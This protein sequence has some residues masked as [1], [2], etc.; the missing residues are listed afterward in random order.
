MAKPSEQLLSF[1]DNAANKEDVAKLFEHLK[2]FLEETK[3]ALEE[4]RNTDR[5][6]GRQAFERLSQSQLE[7]QN[8]L[9]GRAN[10][11]K[12]IMYSESRTLKR[13]VDQQLEALRADFPE[14][15]EDSALRQEFETRLKDIEAKIPT[16][17][18]QQDVKGMIE[19]LRKEFDEKLDTLRQAAAR[20]VSGAVTNLRVQQAFKYILKTEEP[21]GD[22]DG[23]N[24]VYTVSQPIF[25]VL[26]FSLNSAVVAQL[27]NYTISGNKITFASALPSDYSGSDFE[28][29]YI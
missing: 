25:A 29:K 6:E 12:E 21:V 24:T 23:V 26:A 17:P 20:S 11:D 5:E 22:I 27:P 2:K 10:E 8:A 9:L 7:A 18:E 14:P 3:T 1:L 28:I 15:Y 4:L 16:L 13:Y 19:A